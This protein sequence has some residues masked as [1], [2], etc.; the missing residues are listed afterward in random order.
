[1]TSIKIIFLVSGNGGTLK[2][3]HQSIMKK[4]NEFIEITQVIADR[5]CGALQYAKSNDIANS[6]ISYNKNYNIELLQI[7][8]L[9]S[10]DFII[11]NIH[12]ILDKEIVFKFKN[13]LLN[14]HYSI[15]PA[16]KGFI[17][18]KTLSL[19]RESNCKFI[20]STVHFVDENVDNGKI[21]GQLVMDYNLI[22]PLSYYE[23]LI[24]RNSCILLLN[25][26]LF[27]NKYESNYKQKIIFDNDSCV[28]YNPD[29]IFNS[30][31]IYDFNFWEEL[32]QL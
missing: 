18:M 14:L 9:S 1:M 16:F 25:T 29:L 26:I 31:I 2:F 6:V 13:R 12:K 5:E 24:F 19:A 28:F 4:K 10:F 15:L 8:N 22:F 23:D 32:K 3:F 27:L 17:G 20:G 30:S 11:T 21:L 7:L